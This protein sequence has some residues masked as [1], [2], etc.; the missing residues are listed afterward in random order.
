MCRTGLRE[1]VVNP[2]MLRGRITLVERVPFRPLEPLPGLPK[3]LD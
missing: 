3:S 2:N 1:I